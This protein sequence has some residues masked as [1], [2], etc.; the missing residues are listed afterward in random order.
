M[1]RSGQVTV[2][3]AASPQ[4][5]SANTARRYYLLRAHPDNSGDLFIGNDGD[6]SVSETTG[7]ML[8]TTDSPIDFV[9]RLS[10][11]YVKAEQDG[12]KLMWILWVE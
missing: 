9:G 7:F 5:V 1:V 11:L 8:K 10:D 4:Q 3:S 2:T 12:D 6:G